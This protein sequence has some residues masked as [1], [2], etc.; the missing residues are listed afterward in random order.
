LRLSKTISVPF[1]RL[2][3]F[4]LLPIV[5]DGHLHMETQLTTMQYE[6]E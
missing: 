6:T 1:V 3:V 5:R 2:V 4:M